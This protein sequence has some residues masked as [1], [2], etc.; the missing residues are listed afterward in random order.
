MNTLANTILTAVIAGLAAAAPVLAPTLP[1][2]AI[3]VGAAV[4]EI[5]GERS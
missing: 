5:M 1:Q 3:V 2:V 4:V